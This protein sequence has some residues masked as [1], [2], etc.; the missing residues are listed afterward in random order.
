MSASSGR[1]LNPS[2]IVTPRPRPLPDSCSSWLRPF[3][4]TTVNASKARHHRSNNGGRGEGAGVSRPRLR[5]RAREGW[6][7]QPPFGGGEKRRKQRRRHLLRLNVSAGG[8]R[9]NSVA[10]VSRARDPASFACLV[11]RGATRRPWAPSEKSP[12]PPPPPP[13]PPPG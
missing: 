10:R 7:G 3:Q 11:P 6:A 9:K 2:L 8:S 5:R 13:P 4:Q 12:L 1:H